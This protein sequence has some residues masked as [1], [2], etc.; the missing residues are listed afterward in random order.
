[1]KRFKYFGFVAFGIFIFTFFLNGHS[2]QVITCPSGDTYVCVR[3]V[4]GG[5]VLGTTYRGEGGVKGGS[6]L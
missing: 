2:E 1:M 4:D 3:F 5:E 6:K